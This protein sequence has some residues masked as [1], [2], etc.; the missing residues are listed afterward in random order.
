MASDTWKLRIPG[1]PQQQQ[2]ARATAV[3]G[4][5]R[6]YEPADSRNAKAFIRAFVANHKPDVM[7]TDCISVNVTFGIQR[8]KSW[9]K[10][11]IYPPGKPDLDNY[12]KLLF[13]ALEGLV[14]ENDSRI[15]YKTSRKMIAGGLSTPGYIDI[16]IIPVYNESLHIDSR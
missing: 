11:W 12:E 7:F 13:D 5:A 6:M 8:K 15:V 3:S 2:R 4:R 16:E 9:P 1:E 14:Y 10:K